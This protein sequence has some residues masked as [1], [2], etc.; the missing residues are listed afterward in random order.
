[1]KQ[2][3]RRIIDARLDGVLVA[4]YAKQQQPSSQIIG[5]RGV[6]AM[7]AGDIEVDFS[8]HCISQVGLE[9]L[10]QIAAKANIQRQFSQMCKGEI[11]NVSEQRPA[12]HT[13]LRVPRR[14]QGKS[15]QQMFEQME[16][17][18]AMVRDGTWLGVNSK[19]IRTI[20]N[21]GIGGSSLGPDFGY[22]AL[23]DDNSLPL[24]QLANIDPAAIAG[25]LG[26]IDIATTLFIV[27]SK[28]LQTQET[29]A[30]LQAIRQYWQLHYPEDAFWQQAIAVTAA[31]QQALQLGFRTNAIVPMYDWIG[32]RFSL[33]SAAGLSIAIAVGWVAFS[34]LLTGG[35]IIDE[36]AQHS[37]AQQNMPL[38]MA[39]LGFWYKQYW[40]CQTEALLVYSHRLRKFPEYCQQLTMESN[41]KSVDI[42]GKVIHYPTASIVWGGENTNGQ[43]A[44]H[45]L[46]H[47]G[48][49]VVPADFI[50]P[51][52][53]DT[54]DG[55]D[56]AAMHAA[57]VANALAQAKAFS[58]GEQPDNP[59]GQVPGNKPCSII[60]FGAVSPIS[61]GG[62]VALYEH[63]T[64]FE[65]LL[66]NINPF[67]QFGVLLGK[68]LA[69]NI[70][71]SMHNSQQTDVLTTRLL[72]RH[73]QYNATLGSSD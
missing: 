18:V 10:Y 25:V 22:D 58:A 40:R 13:Q 16:R 43:H 23:A 66:C 67:D 3:E 42:D 41:G 64:V 60:S 51:L 20:V 57:L 56:T 19:P 6:L 32:G 35:N 49:H 65:A 17:I 24:L 47:Q 68:K 62:L 31:W 72:R 52:V 30:N 9:A 15:A 61:V 50:L 59:Y 34:G 21:I 63:K 28:S 2:H 45:Q 48:S 46:L 8:R 73:R 12:W 7:Q 55:V 54:L 14:E 26:K 53:T 33:W 37:P 1:M 71:T 39:L 69:T 38:T 27:V 36:H 11:V 29:H 4:E 44:F 70:L 5:R